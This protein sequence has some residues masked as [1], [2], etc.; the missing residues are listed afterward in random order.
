MAKKKYV[1]LHTV[2]YAGD[3]GEQKI[4]VAR[5]PARGELGLFD[6]EFT[7]KQEAELLALGSIRLATK[8]DAEDADEILAADNASPLDHDGDGEAGGSVDELDQMTVAELKAVAEKEEVDLT[9]VTKKADII[10]AIR[11]GR[12]NL[13]A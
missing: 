13:L 5:N 12:E 3:K 4:A 9:D 10:A 8:A 11:A 2:Y 7:A 1:A 6:A